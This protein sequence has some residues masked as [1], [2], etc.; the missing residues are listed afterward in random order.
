[1]HLRLQQLP[2][3]KLV[4]IGFFLVFVLFLVGGISALS[5]TVRVL[6]VLF[7][8]GFSILQATVS[9]EFDFLERLIL[10]P[11]VGIAFTSLLAL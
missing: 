10:S 9:D 2:K 5:L 6:F 11:I 3:F 4:V 7:L 1:M 8:P